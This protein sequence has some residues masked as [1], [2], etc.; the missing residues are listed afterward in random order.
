MYLLDNRKIYKARIIDCFNQGGYKM[1]EVKD[2]KGDIFGGKRGTGIV[3]GR[4]E[5]EKIVPE[6]GK[7]MAYVVEFEGGIRPQALIYAVDG[8]DVEL[9]ML[10][11]AARVEAG[12]QIKEVDGNAILC[13]GYGVNLTYFVSGSTGCFN[14]IFRR[15]GDSCDLENRLLLSIK[16]IC[17]KRGG[18]KK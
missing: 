13:D 10:T 4:G 8:D 11:V 3:V 7:D 5:R 9:Y 6:R 17:E 2:F 12:K 16:R 15:E 1:I 18:K 14:D